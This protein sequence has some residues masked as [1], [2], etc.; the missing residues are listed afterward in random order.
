MKLPGASAKWDGLKRLT[1]G[2]KIA[3]FE[4]ANR[5][6]RAA[7]DDLFFNRG[8]I[9]CR[10]RMVFAHIAKN[11]NFPH[12]RAQHIAGKVSAMLPNA[13]YRGRYHTN[14]WLVHATQMK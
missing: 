8:S 11:R 9:V 2:F 4:S 7:L 12:R 3:N 5:S 13:D 1:H 10:Q 14:L 6:G